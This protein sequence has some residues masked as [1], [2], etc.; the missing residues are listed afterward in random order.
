MRSVFRSP[1]RLGE[2]NTDDELLVNP[3]RNGENGESTMKTIGVLGGLGPQATMDFEARVHRVAQRLLPQHQNSGYPPM[4]VFYYRHPPILL[5]EDHSPRLPIQPD[6]RLLEVAKRAGA[7]ADF[8]V[9]T[10][11]TPHLIQKEIEQAAGCKVL[12]MIA[13]TLEET[14]R[15]QWRKIGVLG[16]GEP[17]VYTQ[18]MAELNIA[19]ET[20]DPGLRTKLDGVIMKLME[21]RNDAAST[22]IAREAIAVLRA[23][24]V[25]GIILGCT[26][27]PL[28]LH[29]HGE[30]PDLVNPAQLLAEATVR[31]ALA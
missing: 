13:A 1:R 21:G 11:N 8:L 9:I 6:P 2:S 3:R 30:A 22:A 5:H 27:I 10:S 28:M 14:Q 7:V 24:K 4:I 15:R 31:S 29:E 12:S 17:I 16:Y 18:P 25:E 19:Y 26:E 20:I 23:K